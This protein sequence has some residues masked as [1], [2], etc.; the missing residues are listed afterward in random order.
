LNGVGSRLVFKQSFDTEPG[1]DLCIVEAKG[2]GSPQ[3]RT[4]AVFSGSQPEFES[5][6]LD[7]SAFDGKTK[8]S[9]RFS[10]ITDPFVNEGGWWIDD[11]Q[12]QT[13]RTN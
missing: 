6:S 2:K 12:V 7:L 13:G 5:V 8:V 4:I 11:V 9:I 3:W 1:Y 10:L